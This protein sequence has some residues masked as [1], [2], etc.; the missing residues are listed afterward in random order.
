MC[1]ARFAAKSNPHAIASKANLAEL[2]S[3]NRLKY[4]GNDI[5]AKAIDRNAR[6]VYNDLKMI[7]SVLVAKSTGRCVQRRRR[8]SHIAT[9]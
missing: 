6:L 3:K 8:Y 4:R 9:G 5:C 7:G 2:D 1:I